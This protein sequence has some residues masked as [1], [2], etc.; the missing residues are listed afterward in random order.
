MSLDQFFSNVNPIEVKEASKYWKSVAPRTN[1]ERFRRWLFAHTSI[2][3][4]WEG[5]VRSYNAIKDFEDWIDDKD[6][7]LKKL[8]DAKAGLH[9]LRTEYIWEFTKDYFENPKEYS[10]ANETWPEFRNRLANKL[11][12]IGMAKVSFA[13]EM[14]FPNEAELVCLDTHML[15]L[16][17]VKRQNFHTP[18]GNTIYQEIEQDW[19]NRAKA[20]KAS[21]YIARCIFWDKKQN[22]SDSRY[23]SHVLEN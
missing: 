23:W 2:H 14:C 3:T 1:E 8:T 20:L 9:N 22:Q 18:K 16:Y 6:L 12:G 19:I 15:K 5:N 21:P 10:R 7:L 13:L 11:R 4:T 17:D